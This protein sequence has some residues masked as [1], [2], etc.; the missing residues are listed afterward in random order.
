M[1][2][3]PIRDTRLPKM[4]IALAMIYATRPV[5]EVQPIQTIQCVFELELRWIESRR[6]RTKMYLAGSYSI[7]QYEL[8]TM[9]QLKCLS[10]ESYMKA[11][12]SCNEEARQRDTVTYLLNHR[13][14]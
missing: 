13:T 11:E 14:C 12:G 3:A 10:R 4:G 9:R 1:H 7:S 6:A 2:R 5:P 8:I